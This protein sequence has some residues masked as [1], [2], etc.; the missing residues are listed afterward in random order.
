MLTSKRPVTT[1][2]QR[3]VASDEELLSANS[4]NPLITEPDETFGK[5]NPSVHM[6]SR[7]K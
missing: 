2:C 5:Q 7:D 6:R 4:N 1:K 3:T